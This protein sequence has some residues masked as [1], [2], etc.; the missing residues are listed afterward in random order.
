MHTQQELT[1]YQQVFNEILTG[2]NYWDSAVKA[3]RKIDKINQGRLA[4][5]REI[6]KELN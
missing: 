6:E 5:A 2:C 3:G 4:L 1:E